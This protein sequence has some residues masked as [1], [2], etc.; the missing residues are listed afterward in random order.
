VFCLRLLRVSIQ[1][2][3]VQFF[4]SCDN[5]SDNKEE[6]QL[7]FVDTPRQNNKKKNTVP[8][9]ATYDDCKFRNLINNS[10]RH[11]QG[12]LSYKHFSLLRKAL[13][14]KVFIRKI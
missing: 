5:T 6:F 14:K 3:V 2:F 11:Q 9:L 1:N 13:G 8:V 10:R 12:Q 7:N 4:S